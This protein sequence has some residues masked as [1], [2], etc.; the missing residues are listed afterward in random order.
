MGEACMRH[1]FLLHGFEQSRLGAGRRAIDLID[2][3]ELGEDR[4]RSKFECRRAPGR[5][6]V[7]LR[8]RD[9]GRHQV[10]S[11]LHACPMQPQRRRERL[12]EVGLPEPG[13]PLDEHVAPG[14]HGG[15]QVGD[16]R[17]LSHDHAIKQRTQVQ[18][19]TM[20]I[21]ESVLRGTIAGQ[22]RCLLALIHACT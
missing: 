2:Q 9:V 22:R 3:D 15:D 10:G 17:S 20:C 13:Q 14:E 5:S 12:G 18:K 6:L 16:E 4:A 21:G 7:N 19:L 11:A 1:L 8:S